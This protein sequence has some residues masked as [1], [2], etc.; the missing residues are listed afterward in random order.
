MGAEE[1]MVEIRG[2]G[3]TDEE[4]AET[5]EDTRLSRNRE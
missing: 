2:Y 4:R 5:L 3:P 1:R